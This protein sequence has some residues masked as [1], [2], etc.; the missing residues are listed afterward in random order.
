MWVCGECGDLQDTH[1]QSKGFHIII[2]IILL[3]CTFYTK[4]E[5]K[6]RTN[7]HTLNSLTKKRQ[8]H[9]LN[10]Y[11]TI[12]GPVLRGYS[13]KPNERGYSCAHVIINRRRLRVTF[14]WTRTSQLIPEDSSVLASPPR[15]SRSHL[16]E[17]E[18][19]RKE[20]TRVRERRRW[21]I[22]LRQASW[23][24]KEELHVEKPWITESK[25]LPTVLR[26]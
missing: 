23:L 24:S 14:E 21:N 16:T 13:V 5:H 22:Q 20:G 11:L 7:H 26:G 19:R 25:R 18:L 4:T 9:H 6:S 10:T 12:N 17:A 3:K 8:I 1:F 2:I 15:I